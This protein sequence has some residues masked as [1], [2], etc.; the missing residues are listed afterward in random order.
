MEE[1]EIEPAIDRV[2]RFNRL[3]SVQNAERQ[4]LGFRFSIDELLQLVN[5]LTGKRALLVDEDDLP[6]AR[7]SLE[8]AELRVVTGGK[9]VGNPYALSVLKDYRNE[10]GTVNT[11]EDEDSEFNNTHYPMATGIAFIVGKERPAMALTVDDFPLVG[12][13]I[14]GGNPHEFFP[15]WDFMT[16]QGQYGYSFS[17]GGGGTGSKTPPPGS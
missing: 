5:Q 9:S 14:P 12:R 2:A 16:V 10:P 11:N 3:R 6:G 4:Y 17:D 1:D 13:N 15:V 7:R 8:G